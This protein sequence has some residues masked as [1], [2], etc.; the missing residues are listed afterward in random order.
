MNIKPTYKK[1]YP[2][3]II[4]I[5]KTLGL[6]YI[7]RANADILKARLIIEAGNTKG[8]SITVRLTSRLTGLE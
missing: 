2:H 5:S 3:N 7:Y 6:T 4:Y 1:D 8:G